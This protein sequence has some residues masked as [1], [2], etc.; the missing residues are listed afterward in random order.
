MLEK[1]IRKLKNDPDY[2]W[3]STHSLRDLLV[4]ADA[5]LGQI[6]RGLFYKPFFKKSAGLVFVGQHVKVRHKYFVTAGK[7]L[8]LEDN[9][10]INALSFEGIEFGNDVS[11]GRNSVLIATGIV[12]H[13]GKG[14]KIGNRTGINA[15][16]YLGGQGGIEIGDDVIT[17]PNIQIFSENHNFSH[18]EIKIKEQGLTRQGVK[19]G[20]NCWIG[21]GVTILDG[22]EIGEGCV[23]AAGSVITKSVPANSIAAGVPAK[24]IK[25]RIGDHPEKELE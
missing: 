8:I 7:N 14:I 18:P 19:I 17:G 24:V 23:I 4:I 9:V 12:S 20:N 10:F 22:V 11:I 3:E 1:I 25:S 21:G 13:K 15:G 6:F 16:A 5:R 2:K